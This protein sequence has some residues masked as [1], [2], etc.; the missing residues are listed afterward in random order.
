MVVGGCVLHGHGQISSCAVTRRKRAL[1]LPLETLAN[2][3]RTLERARFRSDGNA[4]RAR[5]HAL[6]QLGLGL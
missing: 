5:D 1:R 4:V 3:G 2:V 6:A